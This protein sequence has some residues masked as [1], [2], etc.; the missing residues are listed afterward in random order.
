MEDSVDGHSKRRLPLIVCRLRK[1]NF[2]FPFSRILTYIYWN[3]SIYLDIYIYV[4]IYMCVYVYL[5]YIYVWKMET[6]S[7]YRLLI[8]QTEVCRLSICLW[9]N[10]RKLSVSKRTKQTKRT[11]R[12][13]R[14]YPS[15]VDRFS[16]MHKTTLLNKAVISYLPL[17]TSVLW[18]MRYVQTYEKKLMKTQK[19]AVYAS[20]S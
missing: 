17:F 15:L 12:T 13:K 8:V 16:D 2:R 5:I 10:K 4:Y 7:V 9:I 1:V 18:N 3:G 14:T 20:L 19:R 6:E 11:K